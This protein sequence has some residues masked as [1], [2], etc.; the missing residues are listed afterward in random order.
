MT[1]IRATGG[2]LYL[3]V[4]HRKVRLAVSHRKVRLAG[5]HRKVCST[6]WIDL[7]SRRVVG[8]AKGATMEA[9]LV[10]EA[11]NRAL[12]HRQIDAD[13]LLI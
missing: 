13:Q 4:S 8:W 1:T 10:L 9:P 12:G 2:W 5:S 3:A 6:E 7:Y 11:L